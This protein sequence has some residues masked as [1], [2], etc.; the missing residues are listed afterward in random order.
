MTEHDEEL[1]PEDEAEWEETAFFGP[2]FLAMRREV[3]RSLLRGNDVGCFSTEQYRDV[4]RKKYPPPP[5]MTD[6][7]TDNLAR[8]HLEQCDIVQEVAPDVWKEKS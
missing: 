7:L 5:P 3:V 8:M 6:T 1:T 2:I 4:Y